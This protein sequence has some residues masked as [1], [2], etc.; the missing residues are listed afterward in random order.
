M[1][2]K[3]AKIVD[4]DG[5][6]ES[7]ILI[8]KKIIKKIGKN[9]ID[10][11][12]FDA[13]GAYLL[14]GAIDLNVRLLDDKVNIQNIKKLAIDAL[15]GGVTKTIL[16]PNLQPAID[17]E[18]ILEFIKSYSS[19]YGC[20]ILPMIKATYGDD[21][22]KLSDIAILLKKGAITLFFYSDIDSFL[23]CRVFEYAKMFNIPICCRATN[24]SL[25]SVGVMHEGEYSFLLGLGGISQ[26]EES[27]EVAKI[28]EFAKYYDVEVIFQSISLSRSVELI[29]EAKKDGIKVFAEVSIHHLIKSD[30]EC[31]DY[32]TLA[33]IDPPLRDEENKDNLL[34]LLKENEI[35]LLTSL[36]SP[37][38]AVYK[39]V[40]FDDAAFGIDAISLYL[41]LI[42]THLIKNG[43]LK[44]GDLVKILHFN[45]SKLLKMDQNRVKEGFV[46][47]FIIFDQNKKSFVKNRDSLYYN[48]QLFGEVVA[49]VK[50]GDLKLI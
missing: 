19:V 12:I 47:D 16:N 3:N 1:V 48:Q 28:I 42:Y 27:S 38:R 37:K 9:L 40:S 24:R 44:I 20:E 18:I 43:I 31:V 23:I 8:E 46:A 17:N 2:I 36:H 45:P 30:I 34:K 50:D 14:P 35:D 39:D 22:K 7:D 41:S 25:S 11:E 4:L 13:K 6:Y 26:I 21:S 10:S 49:I 32:N 33:K 15:K 5:V 29:K